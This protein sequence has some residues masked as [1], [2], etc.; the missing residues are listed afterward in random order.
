M[1]Q[2]PDGGEDRAVAELFR[3][4]AH[5]EPFFPELRG[6]GVP[7]AVGVD[8]LVDACDSGQRGE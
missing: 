1:V 5:V 7:E 8:A 2:V 6:V 3:D 4:D